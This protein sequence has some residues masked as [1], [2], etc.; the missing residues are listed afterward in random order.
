MMLNLPLPIFLHVEKTVSRL[1]LIPTRAH[2]KLVNTGIARPSIAHIDVAI[3]NFSL[4]LLQEERVKVILHRIKVRP[5]RIGHSRKKNGR[6]HVTTGNL[7]R[8]AGGE[9][10]IPQTKKSSHVRFRQTQV[11]LL[12]LVKIHCFEISHD[13]S[14]LDRTSCLRLV[15]SDNGLRQCH[16]LIVHRNS[17]FGRTSFKYLLYPIPL[18]SGR[19]PGDGGEDWRRSETTNGHVCT[20]NK[21]GCAVESSGEGYENYLL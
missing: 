3:N 20:G 7:G 16:I 11:L 4:R 1:H 18:S 12:E 21:R 17:L 5:R 10:I 19:F 6:L 9:G 14:E 13:T 15:R 8:V 2:R